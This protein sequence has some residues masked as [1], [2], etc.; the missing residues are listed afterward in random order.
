MQNYLDTLR[1]ILEHGTIKHNRTGVDTL[2]TYGRMIEFDMSTGKFPLLTTKKMGCKT[3]FAELEMFIHGIHSKKFLHDRNCHIW[4]EWA[5]PTKVP[6]GHDDETRQKMLEEDDLGPIYG[7]QWVNWNGEGLNQLRNAIDSLKKNPLNRQLVITAW[8]PSKLNEMALPPCHYSFHLDSDGE[9]LSLGW[10]QRSCDWFLGVPFDMASYA[11]LLL[12]ICKETGLKPGKLVG[13]MGDCH[14]YVN[15]IEAAKEQL[16][17]MPKE[18]PY[19]TVICNKDEW[20]IEDWTYT[21]FE[22]TDYDPYPAIK[23]PVAV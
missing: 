11:M 4:D 8:N 18:S 12:L 21:D 13:F 2:W 1:Y 10:N 16:A 14:I 7:S 15:Q 22:L 17:R 19:M 9:Y 3:I 5:N 6:Y 20:H 23:A